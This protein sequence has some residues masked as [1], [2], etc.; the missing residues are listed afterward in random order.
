MSS[1]WKAIARSM[2]GLNH[3]NQ[4]QPCQDFSRYLAL[5]GDIL[6]GAIADGCGSASHGG[7][8]AKLAVMGAINSLEQWH[9]FATTKGEPQW[10]SR[11]NDAKLKRFFHYLLHCLQQ[12]LRQQAKSIG[13]DYSELATTLIVFIAHPQGLSAM[14]LGDGFL[15]TRSQGQDYQLNFI[16]NKGEYANQTVFI[17]S[18]NAQNYVQIIQNEQ[19]VEFICAATDGL[20]NVALKQPEWLAFAPFF[21]P[22]EDY[23]HETIDPEQE[24]EYLDQFLSSER[25]NERTQDDKTL[26]LGLYC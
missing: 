24:P 21:K 26:L 6:L 1:N 19:P 23:L 4:Q 12:E 18:D 16:P 22:L 5:E 3:Q 14:Q 25:L 17:T 9:Q 2:V 13:C 7:L 8:G 15:V 20:E 10:P 11:L